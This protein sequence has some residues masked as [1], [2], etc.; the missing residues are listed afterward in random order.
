MKNR[1]I[2]AFLFVAVLI[3]VTI[4]YAAIQN[5]QSGNQLNQNNASPLCKNCNVV[6]ISIDSLRFDHLGSNT[7]NINNVAADSVFFN[8]YI[9]QSYLTPISEFSLDTSLYPYESGIA[10]SN[11]ENQLQIVNN[12]H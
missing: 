6:L 10:V 5:F 4:A 1:K 12:P 3:L 11:L 9:T 7:P 8:N 2:L